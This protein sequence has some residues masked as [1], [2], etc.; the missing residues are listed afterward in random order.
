MGR[1]KRRLAKVTVKY[2]S[3]NR[4]WHIK[5]TGPLYV[6]ANEHAASYSVSTQ[7]RDLLIPHRET[8]VCFTFC[9]EICHSN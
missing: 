8:K 5:Q 9:L 6:V 1:L 3:K 4:D 7:Q 2:T